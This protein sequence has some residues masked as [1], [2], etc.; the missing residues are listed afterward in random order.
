MAARKGPLTSSKLDEMRR[1]IQATLLLKKLEEHVL[2][3]AEMKAS[4][5]KAAEVLLRKVIPDL[6]N[7]EM[8]GADGG[9]V[10]TVTEIKLTALRAD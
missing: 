1:R 10:Q 4:Q 8:T 5:I 9:P 6:S 2:E 3:G 7:V